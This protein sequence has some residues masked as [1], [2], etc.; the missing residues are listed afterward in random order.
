MPFFLRQT[1]FLSFYFVI[2]ED[3][4]AS[5]IVIKVILHIYWKWSKSFFV[6]LLRF[7]RWWSQ[8]SIFKWTT[9]MS[10]SHTDSHKHTEGILDQSPTAQLRLTV[11]L[12]MADSPGHMN[13][14][15]WYSFP[16]GDTDSTE[17]CVCVCKG[18]TGRNICFPETCV[19][20]GVCL[21]RH[22]SCAMAP[23]ENMHMFLS[24]VNP[25]DLMRYIKLPD[26]QS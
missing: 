10:P 20:A 21:C 24:L 26:N 7:S 14:V 1:A 2:L 4:P 3:W 25:L 8:D 12:R 9:A 6:P 18:S 13:S 23:A 11:G 19:I 17:D 5:E 22:A 15:V 16:T